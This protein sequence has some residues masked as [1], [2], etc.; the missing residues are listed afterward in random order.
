MATAEPLDAEMAERIARHRRHRPGDFLLREEPLDLAGAL[1][2]L[3][4]ETEL[5]ILDCLPVWLGNRFARGEDLAGARTE[6]FLE[7]LVGAPGRIV[8]VTN[9][10]GFEPAPE[11]PACRAY[12]DALADLNRCVAARAD[13]VLLMWAGIPLEVAPRRIRP[14]ADPPRGT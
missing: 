1:R 9:E 10:I 5:A 7:A 11:S 6:A 14:S 12:R 8:V 2:G 13:R 4:E 3:P